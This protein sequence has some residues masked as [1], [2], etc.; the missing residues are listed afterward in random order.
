[1]HAYT[2][3]E[4]GC[5]E[6]SAKKLPTKYSTE[7]NNK[8]V[9][10]RPRSVRIGKTVP[11]V[12][13]T[14]C[15]LGPYSRPLAPFFPIRTSRQANNIYLFGGLVTM[16]HSYVLE[17]NCWPSWFVALPFLWYTGGITH[18]CHQLVSVNANELQSKFTYPPHVR[19]EFWFFFCRRVLANF[20]LTVYSHSYTLFTLPVIYSANYSSSGEVLR[21]LNLH[22]IQLKN[23]LRSQKTKKR[24]L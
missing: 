5:S 17:Y 1:M 20:K 21:I 18:N 10:C 12:L 7:E 3:F 15:G 9:I 24:M 14:A 13:S 23:K 8:H 11:S 19:F 6:N 2:R 4:N 22:F 16:K